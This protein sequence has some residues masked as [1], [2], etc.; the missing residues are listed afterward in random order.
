MYPYFCDVE[1]DDI[2]MEC[3]EPEISLPDNYIV[4]QSAGG[5][6]QYRTYR[7]SDLVIQML[8]DEHFVQLGSG[9]DMACLKAHLDLR[10]KLSWRES[11]WVMKNAKAA[12]V[13]DS[14]LSHLAGTLGTPAVVLFGPAP[15]RVTGPKGDPNKLKF[16]EPNKLDV[17]PS[18]TSCW[19]QPGMNQCNSPCINT[20]HPMLVVRALQEL[21]QPKEAFGV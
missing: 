5:Q 7:H 18:L 15:A 1:A 2:H 21:L 14:S 8:P 6:K 13:I 3:V 10:E 19:G 9:M 16:L 17:C 11:A 20:I 12:V 4:I